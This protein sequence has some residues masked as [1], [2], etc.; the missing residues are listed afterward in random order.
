MLETESFVKRILTWTACTESNP[1]TPQ[2]ID[3]PLAVVVAVSV[4]RCTGCY[5]LHCCTDR[6]AGCSSS[7]GSTLEVCTACSQSSCQAAVLGSTSAGLHNPR[8][9]RSRWSYGTSSEPAQRIYH[10][11]TLQYYLVVIW[12]VEL[13]CSKKKSGFEPRL[14]IDKT[15]PYKLDLFWLLLLGLYK[16]KM[17]TVIRFYEG[18]KKNL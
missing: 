1:D 2:L 15:R 17:Y 8:R 10:D 9:W 13:A 14:K 11:H 16:A 5:C 12:T 6:S 18:I 4:R 7:P 3:E